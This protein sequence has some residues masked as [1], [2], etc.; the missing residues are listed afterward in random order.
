[1]MDTVK[2]ILPARLRRVLGRIR[3]RIKPFPC[4]LAVKA[5]SDQPCWFEVHSEQEAGR[6]TSLGD[7]QA[8]IQ[9]MMDAVRPGEVF[10]DVG[11]C[12]G[13]VALLAARRG[14][15]VVAFEPDRGYRK[16][17]LRNLRINQLQE[18]VQVVEW[19]VSDRA[20]TTTLF[21]DGTD[22]NSPSLVEVGKRGRAEV[23][24]DS[25]DAAVAEG[26]LPAPDLVKLDIEGA[27]IL[28]LRGMRQLLG[29]TKAP[30]SLFVELHPD[31]LRG[32]GSSAD[33]CQRLIES[34]GYALRSF[35]VRRQQQ[36]CVF[37]K[38]G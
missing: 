32:F 28:A 6:V 3:Y 27:E 30:R 8:F 31:F 9:Q 12:L 26:R 11:S 24:T 16:R 22:G 34:F 7:E 38:D 5:F 20:G 4:R 18:A 23:R 19:A 37:T 33:E 36:H 21:T 25:L 35:E 13:L 29:S 1:M 10:Y 17:L 15:R 14:A 2:K